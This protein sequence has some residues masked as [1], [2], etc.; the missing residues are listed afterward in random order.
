MPFSAYFI[1]CGIF[2]IVN[3][4]Y[5]FHSNFNTLYVCNVKLLGHTTL[6]MYCVQGDQ[7]I[8]KYLLLLKP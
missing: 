3:K 1:V 7:V 5:D 6:F 4:F 2:L 8:I